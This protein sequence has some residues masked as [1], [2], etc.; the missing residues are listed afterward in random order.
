MTPERES[1]I[2]GLR[3]RHASP[4]TVEM[5]VKVIEEFSNFHDKSPL[6][7][8]EEDVQTFLFHCVNIRQFSPATTNLY[9]S[10]M[11]SFYAIVDPLNPI[12]N[13]FRK[14]HVEKKIPHILSMGEVRKI[15]NAV[16]TV[17]YRAAIAVM[18]SGGLRIH[19]CLTL[20]PKHIDRSRMAIRVENGKGNKPRLFLFEGRD[21][22]PMCDTSVSTALKDAAAKV[23]INRPVYPHLLRHCFATHLLEN[24]VE[25]EII[26]KM[27]GHRYIST[28]AHYAHITPEMLRKVVSPLDTLMGRQHG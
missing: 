9:I 10:A 15:V 18:Y 20:Q 4:K 6:A 19:E 17:K 23:G 21:M 16:P 24:G 3:V 14:L 2:V 28:T 8:V 5:Y 13:H 26:Q 11:R 22:R 1:F 27:M 7:M 12:M 25:L